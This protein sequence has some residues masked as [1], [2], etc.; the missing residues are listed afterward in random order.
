MRKSAFERSKVISCGPPNGAMSERL[1]LDV[2]LSSTEQNQDGSFSILDPVTRFLSVHQH[3]IL[4]D[5]LY[6]TAYGLLLD[7]GPSAASTMF[8]PL[9]ANV[10]AIL[11]GSTLFCRNQDGGLVR[12]TKQP[13]SGLQATCREVRTRYTISTMTAPANGGRKPRALP[14]PYHPSP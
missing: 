12:K 11:H 9:L 5:Y 14:S 8:P 4:F 3:H 2:E 1:S 7:F 6:P 10:L 13:S